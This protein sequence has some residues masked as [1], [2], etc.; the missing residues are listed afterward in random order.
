MWQEL[1]ELRR[2]RRKDKAASE[3]KM[4]LQGIWGRLDTLKSMIR[5]HWAEIS[6]GNK[7]G[8]KERTT[9]KNIF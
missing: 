3:M 8:N 2:I 9:L 1:T 7:M 4:K 5:I 6:K